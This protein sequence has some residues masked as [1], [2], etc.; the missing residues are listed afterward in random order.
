ME[1]KSIKKDQKRLVYN[2][3]LKKGIK[4]FDHIN[5][6]ILCAPC[7]GFGDVI[8]ATKLK[9]YIMDWYNI[10][11][12]IA[13]TVSKSF[14]NLGEPAKNII[15]LDGK[16]QDQCRR[17]SRLLPT[18]S[19]DGYDLIL[20]APLQGDLTVSFADIKHLIPY[21]NRTNTFIFSEY[22]D[23]ITKNFD[24]NTGIG[25]GRDGMFFVNTNSQKKDITKFG[26]KKYAVA[27]ISGSVDRSHLC[28]VRFIQMV[29]DK[30]PDLQEIV[31]QDWAVEISNKYFIAHIKGVDNI[32]L[33]TINDLIV[34]KNSNSSGRRLT[35]RCDVL[36]VA[37]NIMIG[38]IKYSVADILITGD[39]SLSDVLSCCAEHKN[40]FYQI[41]PWKTDLAK[42]LTKEL[43]NKFLK[44]SKTS[45]GCSEAITYKSDYKNF[46]KKWDFRTRGKA[47]IDAMISS[48]NILKH[49]E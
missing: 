22:N 4:L 18:K 11:A 21:S 25:K 35:L 41:V 38:I 7:K 36:P 20:V 31:C 2:E 1:K 14:V 28:L 16:G 6:L 8:F 30:Y 45:C 5:I 24:I 23:K 34:V 46:V 17:F 9:H 47:K 43:P 29:I 3:C 49:T 12:D 32:Y 26:L 44:S 27:Y 48:V 15:Q 13:T 19:L 39:Q 10:T 42:E 40:I 33:K 37:N